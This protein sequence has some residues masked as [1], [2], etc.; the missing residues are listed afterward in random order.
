M[1]A[2]WPPYPP[3][4]SGSCEDIICCAHGHKVRWPELLGKSEQEATSTIQRE[5]PE[6][7][8]EVLTPGRVGLNDF[9]CNRVYL[10]VD[11]NNNV[12]NIPSVG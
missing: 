11:A 7:T 5:N 3:C 10:P 4:V 12:I 9:C 2:T 1:S 8:V 6:V